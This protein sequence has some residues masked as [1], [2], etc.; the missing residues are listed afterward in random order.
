MWGIHNG[1]V[2]QN[3][4]VVYAPKVGQK[5]IELLDRQ[6]LAANNRVQADLGDQQPTTACKLVEAG[7]YD[8]PLSAC[9]ADV[10]P[11]SLSPHM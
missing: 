2:E 5:R 1:R 10:L 7:G 11:L 8:P 4:S 9:K 3:L 6:P